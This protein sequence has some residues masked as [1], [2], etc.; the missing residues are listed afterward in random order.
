MRRELMTPAN[1]VKAIVDAPI[2]RRQHHHGAG[3]LHHKAPARIPN[4]TS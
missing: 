1:E 3:D 4:T 2:G